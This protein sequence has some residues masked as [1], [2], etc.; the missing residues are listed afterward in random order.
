MWFIGIIAVGGIIGVYA[1]L[2]APIENS[3]YRVLFPW[4]EPYIL[5]IYYGVMSLAAVNVFTSNNSNANNTP[6]LMTVYWL[7]TWLL[8]GLIFIGIRRASKRRMEPRT[9]K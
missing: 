5:A 2:R 4:L 6:F 1:Y 9:G 3:S 7:G 8:V